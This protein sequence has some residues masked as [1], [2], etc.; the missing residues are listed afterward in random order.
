MFIGQGIFEILENVLGLYPGGV[1]MLQI[2]RITAGLFKKVGGGIE[3]D[4]AGKMEELFI[5]IY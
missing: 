2:V 4:I 1:F 3:V 5:G